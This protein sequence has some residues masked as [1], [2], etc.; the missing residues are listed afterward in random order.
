MIFYNKHFIQTV[1][2]SYIYIIS[3]WL[4]QEYF[5]DLV[6]D[7]VQ[8]GAGILLGVSGTRWYGLLPLRL[9]VHLKGLYFVVFHVV[10]HYLQVVCI[11]Y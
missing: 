9:M 11:D 10:A 6:W 2:A 4:T 7:K 1:S 5:Q 3:W 8:M